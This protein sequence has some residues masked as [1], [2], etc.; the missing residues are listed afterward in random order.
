[1]LNVEYTCSFGKHAESDTPNT[2]SQATASY[3]MPKST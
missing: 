3:S 1:M 2:Q